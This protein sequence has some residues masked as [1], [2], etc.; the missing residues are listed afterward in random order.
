MSEVGIS[1]ACW[2]FMQQS[3]AEVLNLWVIW[4]HPSPWENTD[5][6]VAIHNGSKM[7]VMK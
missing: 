7:T 1:S 6:Y 3:T 5:I 2:I 4:G